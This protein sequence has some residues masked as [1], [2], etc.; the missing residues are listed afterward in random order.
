MEDQQ[1]FQRVYYI[2]RDMVPDNR[3]HAR[4]SRSKFKS[5]S[6]S[7][8]QIPNQNSLLRDS[9]I[10]IILTN[11]SRIKL[12]NFVPSETATSSSSHKMDVG[13]FPDY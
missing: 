5:S 11:P 12:L 6:S 10:C 9:T 7:R 1:V 3:S 2:E 4:F 13:L 8:Y